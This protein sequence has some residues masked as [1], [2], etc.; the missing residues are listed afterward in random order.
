MIHTITPNNPLAKF[1]F[2][3]PTGSN[4]A[5]LEV[6]DSEGSMLL[7]GNPRKVQLRWNLRLPPGHF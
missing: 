5:G 4:A 3:V 1:L 6:L 7:P 2:L